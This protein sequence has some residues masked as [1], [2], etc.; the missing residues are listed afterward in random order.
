MLADRKFQVPAF[1]VTLE[2]LP[3]LVMVSVPVV[4]IVEQL[5]GGLVPPH[6]WVES[7]TVTTSVPPLI[8]H[9]V[10]PLVLQPIGL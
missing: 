3:V 2:L 10:M 7:V 9:G 6:P 1:K 5:V 8:L 4:G